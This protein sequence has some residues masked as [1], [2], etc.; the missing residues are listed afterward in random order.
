[1]A[2][3][4]LSLYRMLRLSDPLPCRVTL[5]ER[6]YG[7]GRWRTGAWVTAPLQLPCSPL[8][9]CFWVF[10]PPFSGLAGAAVSSGSVMSLA[11]LSIPAAASPP[12][13]AP[14]PNG[15]SK[16]TPP[17]G[18]GPGKRVPQG[19]GTP[20]G[21]EPQPCGV[22][23]AHGTGM[24]DAQ[25]ETVMGKGRKKPVPGSQCDQSGCSGRT[26]R[27]YAGCNCF[28]PIFS[29]FLPLPFASSPF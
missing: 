7:E 19:W 24:W 13:L 18:S 8:G 4:R 25:R 26:D 23:A 15:P 20:L 14:L 11:A 3:L 6:K 2:A 5:D 12:L 22:L 1:M 27:R 9:I 28:I 21:W 17:A 16:L 29:P 10:F